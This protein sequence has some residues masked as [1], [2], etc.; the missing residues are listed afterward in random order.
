M[1]TRVIPPDARWHNTDI[2]KLRTLLEEVLPDNHSFRD[3]EVEHDFPAIGRRVI[4]LDA[5]QVRRATNGDDLI[6]LAIEDI[7]E[8]RSQ[9]QALQTSELRYRRLFETARD[10]ILILDASTGKIID[11]NPFMSELLGYTKEE[12]LGQELWQIGFFRDIDASR[13]AFEE[14]Q[15]LGY[16]RYEDLPLQN[17]AGRQTEVEF[18]S[19]LY[20]VDHTPIIQCNIRDITIRRQLERAK[21]KAETLADSNR[22]KD[23]FLAMLS[24]E[25]RNPLAAI[26]IAS[27]LLRH[28]ENEDLIQRQAHATLVRQV[29]QLTHLVDDLLEISRIT[30]GRI[31]LQLM[32]VDLRD[33]V[34]RA[35][36]SVRPLIK[37]RRHE[38]SVSSPL[39]PIFLNAGPNRME[40]VLV[41]LLTN[42]AKYTDEG[43][44]I[45]L[46]VQRE[47][48]EAV[49]RVRDTG[50][51][52]APNLLPHIF[53][54]FTQADRS[55]DRSEGG[56]G[57]GLTLV[58]S[59]VEMHG[60]KAEANSEGLGQGSEFSVRLPVV[61][62]SSPQP[63]SEPTEKADQP[64][65][66]WRVLAVDDQIDTA[67]MI[68]NLLRG[69][70]YD[71]RTAYT[72]PAALE[73][74]VAYQPDILLLDIGLPRMDGYEVA[75]HL[76]QNPQLKN[77]SLVAMT[78]YGTEA[79][80]E[81]CREAGFDHHLLK[82]I[83]PRKLRELMKSLTGRERPVE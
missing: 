70:G 45:W 63:L 51:G 43:G 2:P 29:G 67:E 12:L 55:L 46:T 1:Y 66:I 26:V 74:A 4:L 82:P 14:L 33:V 25:L 60:G 8:R 64:T 10:G 17:R 72:G 24:H 16:I 68:G 15:D 76:R 80:I 77:V 81:L 5:R 22:R 57:I 27:D 83:Y 21:L 40:Q 41:N 20:R 53:D 11:S 31:R 35:V 6:L 78:G 13:A 37:R 69:W 32:N 38:L 79:D 50:I 7:T 61:L 28:Q 52:I 62:F 39:E 49:L 30:T 3:F 44:R 36:E 65:R 42:A 75:R 19:N 47:G 54:L 71:V 23:E 48:N 59:L 9:E 56:L 73:V 58:K 34:E 18:V